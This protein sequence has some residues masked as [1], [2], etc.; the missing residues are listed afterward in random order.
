[1][2]HYWGGEER[3]GDFD[4][5]KYTQIRNTFNQLRNKNQKSTELTEFVFSIRIELVSTLRQRASEIRE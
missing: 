1:M 5:C 4:I 3:G 2:F